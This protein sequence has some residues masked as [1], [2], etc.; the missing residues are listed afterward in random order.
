[1]CIRDRV[2]GR[3]TMDPPLEERA[4]GNPTAP[5]DTMSPLRRCARGLDAGTAIRLDIEQLNVLSRPSVTMPK[6]TR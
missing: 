4:E 1:M 2:M 6:G 5:I 3:V